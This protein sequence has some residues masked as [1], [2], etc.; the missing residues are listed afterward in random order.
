MTSTNAL[1]DVVSRTAA[2]VAAKHE[3]GPAFVDAPILFVRSRSNGEF[4]IFVS[5][6]Y[7]V[8][9]DDGEFYK[10]TGRIRFG[11]IPPVSIQFG[12]GES[13]DSVFVPQEQLAWFLAQLKQ[14]QAMVLEVPIIGG[15]RIVAHFTPPTESPL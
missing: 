6:D 9:S 8:N 7:G 10:A 3:G 14:G 2:L 12:M 1:D 13:R 11:Q 5:M 15:G 4:D